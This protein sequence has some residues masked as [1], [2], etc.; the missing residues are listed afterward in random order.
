M[1]VSCVQCS[2][3]AA[4]D[5]LHTIHLRT[6][7]DFIINNTRNTKVNE[8]AFIHWFTSHI[9]WHVRCIVPYMWIR[10]YVDLFL[11]YKLIMLNIMCK[12]HLWYIIDGGITQQWCGC[13]MYTPQPIAELASIRFYSHL[14]G[15]AFAMYCIR[16]CI[17]Q[18]GD[19][20][21]RWRR[22][23]T[24]T[25]RTHFINLI[26]L[27]I[28]C[29]V[30]THIHSINHASCYSFADSMDAVNR[31][32]MHSKYIPTNTREPD[33]VYRRVQNVSRFT[34]FFFVVVAVVWCFV[35][36][37][38]LSSSQFKTFATAETFIYLYHIYVYETI[39]IFH[40]NADQINIYRTYYLFDN[41]IIMDR[42]VLNNARK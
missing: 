23:T 5:T 39:I 24:H 4:S 25:T 2:T 12:I 32:R 29:I 13:C 38:K 19:G 9:L 35:Y 20:E 6:H 21:S 16:A 36:F 42:S 28:F 7:L 33:Q 22:E 31:A 40:L 1:C 18:R 14:H 27:G 17:R 30:P 34:I 10:L 41:I 8:A 15:H 37:Q 3:L 26:I 11:I